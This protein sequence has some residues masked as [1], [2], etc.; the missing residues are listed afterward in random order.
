MGI[1]SLGAAV[2]T[3]ASALPSFEVGPAIAL[4]SFE[5]PTI[6]L[7]S[8]INEA[9]AINNPFSESSFALDYAAE[10]IAAPLNVADVLFEAEAILSGSA[11][12]PLSEASLVQE[13]EHWLSSPNEI[14]NIEEP[15][16]DVTSELQQPVREGLDFLSSPAAFLDTKPSRAYTG[17]GDVGYISSDT[18]QLE[19]TRVALE[20]AGLIDLSNNIVQTGGSVGQNVSVSVGQYIGVSDEIGRSVSQYVSESVGQ[21]VGES[22]APNLGIEQRL[23]E[24]IVEEV[25]EEREVVDKK[26][27]QQEIDEEEIEETV[28]R[29]V[30]D[31]IV[32]AQRRYEIKEAIKK[33]KVEAE[34]EGILEV[35][36]WRIVKYLP[37]ESPENR[38]QLVKKD[39][40]DGSRTETVDQIAAKKFAS[41]TDAQNQT[42]Y[43]V[44]QNKPVKRGVEGRIVEGKDVQ[45]V[46][47][48]RII[49]AHLPSEIVTLRVIK[50][51]VQVAS[52]VKVKQ[53]TSIEDYPALAEVF[54]PNLQTSLQ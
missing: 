16:L 8:I 29:Y 19:R 27:E 17:F 48:Y 39:G 14:V 7:S 43:I 25:E 2:T 1:E 45:K 6:G 11:T 12:N 44:A 20:Q 31:E 33:A 10:S 50:K 30:E 23:V 26:G 24:Q 52:S 41:A 46:Y 40:P 37:A 13:A 21:N 34:A 36:G 47:K 22:P 9:P 28:V 4:P 32:S 3:A 53:E 18:A 51:K 49:K 35:E 15:F 5:A 54:S 38:S 42:D